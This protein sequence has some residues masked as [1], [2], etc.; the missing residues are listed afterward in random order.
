ML[1]LFVYYPGHDVKLFC[2]KAPTSMLGIWG[3]VKWPL[4]HPSCQVC[5]DPERKHLFAVPAWSLGCRWW[6]SL[7]DMWD[8]FTVLAWSGCQHLAGAAKD[9]GNRWSLSCL[10]TCNLLSEGVIRTF[11][12]L[13]STW[14]SGHWPCSWDLLLPHGLSVSDPGGGESTW[15]MLHPPK[16]F[17]CRPNG[18]FPPAWSCMCAAQEWQSWIYWEWQGS[19]F[20]HGWPY[21][22]M[23]SLSRGRL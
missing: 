2:G 20:L 4:S 12:W 11:Y 19:K 15:T 5:S 8:I 1:N 10:G 22:G 14:Q 23:P 21:L 6:I 7:F 16:T 9:H 13:A 18:N 17:L 3:I